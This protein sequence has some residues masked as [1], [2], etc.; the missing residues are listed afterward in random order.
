MHETTLTH[1]SLATYFHVFIGMLFYFIFMWFRSF[2]FCFMCF[3][4]LLVFCFASHFFPLR[5]FVWCFFFCWVYEEKKTPKR[6]RSN[7]VLS[8][9]VPRKKS[10]NKNTNVYKRRSNEDMKK[11]HKLFI[12]GRCVWVCCAQSIRHLD[13]NIGLWLALMF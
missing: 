2:F 4:W 1:K 7:V 11:W 13:L 5:F 12:W 8:H 3:S 6:Y 10:E 9:T